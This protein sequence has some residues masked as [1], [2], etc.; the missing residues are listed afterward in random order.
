MKNK[1]VN[2]QRLLIIVLLLGLLIPAPNA[3]AQETSVSLSDLEISSFDYTP[4]QPKMGE[5]VIVSAIV[6]NTS[7]ADAKG[8]EVTITADGKEIHRLTV[9]VPA[10]QSQKMTH[11]WTAGWD[12]IEVS[13]EITNLSGEASQETTTEQE[14]ITSTVAVA[15]PSQSSETSEGATDIF[16]PLEPFLKGLD[17]W[18]AVIVH[19]FEGVYLA[20]IGI[21]VHTEEAVEPTETTP[22]AVAEKPTAT[23]PPS[24]PVPAPATPTVSLAQVVAPKPPTGTT[25]ST[26]PAGSNSLEIVSGNRQEWLRHHVFPKPLIVKLTDSKKRPLGDSEVTFKLGA[27]S[28]E[29]SKLY[30]SEDSKNVFGKNA[31]GITLKTD[32]DGLAK[33]YIEASGNPGSLEI[34]VSSPNAKPVSF[35]TT[36][37][38]A[39]IVIPKVNE[40]VQM[41]DIK[42]KA[43]FTPKPP[44]DTPLR[45]NW[46]ILLGGGQT[47]VG[48]SKPGKEIILKANPFPNKNEQFGKHLIAAN[49]VIG[50]NKAQADLVEVEFFFAKQTVQNPTPDPNWFYFWKQGAVVPRMGGFVYNSAL[51]AYGQWDP[52]NKRLELGE[53]ACMQHYMKPVTITIPAGV[54]V[55][56]SFGKPETL[57][58]PHFVTGPTKLSFGGLGVKGIDC[59]AEI[60]AH[61]LTHKQIQIYTTSNTWP[62]INLP[63]ADGDKVPDKTERV[64][65]TDSTS[66]DA[67]SAKSGLPKSVVAKFNKGQKDSDEDGISDT[68]ETANG[69]NPN[70]PDTD[71][72][73]LPDLLE[74]LI[75]TNPLSAHTDGIREKLPDGVEWS[76][77]LD[78][79]NAD[80]LNVNGVKSPIDNTYLTYGDNEFLCLVVGNSGR[81]V[82]AKDWAN[83]GKQSRAPL[84]PAY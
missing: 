76:L 6:T 10:G 40:P 48:E 20:V 84:E 7:G 65:G 24:P 35:K 56:I 72:D 32:K 59:A 61:E 78:P 11:Q 3:L 63:D 69:L 62:K 36:S 28:E 80:T 70:N 73:G 9:D 46:E 77:G 68:S 29:G 38:V 18:A 2:G 21:F 53:D 47:L 17:N 44:D 74:R 13:A 64:L 16:A 67:T 12:I 57:E 39:K 82:T 55:P 79:T 50:A 37:Y 34:E 14:V 81:G 66:A 31:N 41:P 26:K 43:D 83:A 58:D 19:W 5:T 71:G 42:L 23:I 49:L 22:T 75:G 33:T 54:S 45:I 15:Q 52:A 51:D 27:G 4:S 1:S 25:E 30:F 8:V 60:C